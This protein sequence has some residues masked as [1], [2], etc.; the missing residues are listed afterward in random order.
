MAG[1]SV[2]K[3]AELLVFSRATI[4]DHDRI[5]EA[6]K[7]LINQSKSGCNS[8]LTDIN[9]RALK[10][11]LRSKH[12]YCRQSNSRVKSNIGIVQFQAKMFAVSSIKPDI[13]EKSP[14]GNHCLP[15][16][17]FRWGWSDVRDHKGWSADQWKQV[18]FGQPYHEILSMPLLPCMVGSTAKI[19]WTFWK[20][21]FVHMIQAS[22]PDGDGIFQYDN[23]PIHT[24][25]HGMKSIKAV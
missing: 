5:Q 19:T 14:W 11:I 2:T 6:R 8:K 16:S 3:T 23:V 10:H 12:D 4:K 25:I 15:L 22:F 21:M 17:R 1:A 7:T 24:Y 9:R 13:M 20:I 18:I